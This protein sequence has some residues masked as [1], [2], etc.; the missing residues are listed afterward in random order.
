MATRIAMV[1]ANGQKYVPMPGKKFPGVL[2]KAKKD[3]EAMATFLTEN[4]FEILRGKAMCEQNLV[5][6]TDSAETFVDAVRKRKPEVALL[7]Y[8]GHGL[9][10]S[11]KKLFMGV[12]YKTPKS[13]R[14]N[15]KICF[16]P[17]EKVIDELKGSETVLIFIFDCCR[18]AVFKGELATQTAQTD[19]NAKGM[20]F[21]DM[22]TI[23]VWCW[24]WTTCKRRWRCGQV[25]RANAS[26]L[27]HGEE[28]RYRHRRSSFVFRP[29]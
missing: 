1:W 7:Y 5:Q 11:E 18:Q 24:S 29:S 12:D 23:A 25:Q 14:M 4:G 6:M 16:S 15:D 22:S 8:S 28:H 20:V 13:A 10:D 26:H 17:Q 2:P 3:G 19:K 27:G 21:P 9:E